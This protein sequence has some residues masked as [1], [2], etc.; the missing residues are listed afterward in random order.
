MNFKKGQSL[1][2]LIVALGIFVLTIAGLAFFVL[3]SYISGRL[4][5][6]MT[7]VNFLAEEGLEAVRSIRDN[8]WPAL[9]AGSHGL[10][11]SGD[12]WVFQGTSED[13]ADQLRGGRRI[14]EIENLDQNRKKIT[15]RINWQFSETRPEEVKFVSY[16]TNWQKI[17]IGHCVGTCTPCENFVARISCDAQAGCSW[18]AKLKK[19]TGIC[20]PCETF[21]DQPSCE[22]QSGCYWVWE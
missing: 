22:A 13:I 3:D 7:K 10:A 8:S 17:S 4:A 6:E 9:I 15:S 5:S 2:E 11:I 12:H 1:I 21:T 20:I 14:I 18:S 19:C 16:L